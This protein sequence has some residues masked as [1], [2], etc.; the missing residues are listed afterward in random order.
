MTYCFFIIYGFPLMLMD[1][2][3]LLKPIPILQGSTSGLEMIV[4]ILSLEYR[5]ESRSA[6]LI[7]CLNPPYPRNSL[8][9]KIFYDRWFKLKLLKDAALMVNGIWGDVYTLLLQDFF[10]KNINKLYA[11]DFLAMLL[12]SFWPTFKKAAPGSCIVTSSRQGVNEN[13][14][15]YL[16]DFFIKSSW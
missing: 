16:K 1:F 14:K 15:A 6:K 7:F 8:K 9:F 11:Y 3:C 2:Y 5:N 10:V 12:K 13:F 4:V